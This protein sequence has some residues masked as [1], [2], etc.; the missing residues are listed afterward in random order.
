MRISDINQWTKCEAMALHSGGGRS[1]GY[2]ASAYV[3]TLAHYYLWESAK[4]RYEET[5]FPQPRQVAWDR[6]TIDAKEAELQA[7]H[8]AEAGLLKLKADDWVITETERK[9][10]GGRLDLVAWNGRL[11]KIALLDLKTGGIG[12]GWLQVAGYMVADAGGSVDPADIAF[13]FGGILWVPRVRP[14]RDPVA[15]LEFRPAADLLNAWTTWET[16]IEEVVESG[17]LPL[18]SPGPHCSRCS[19]TG[20]PVRVETSFQA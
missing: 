13:D 20:C 19:L 15:T 7:A 2:P 5:E 18:R 1:I 14:E 4:T 8:I 16:R 17:R 9:V 12:G 10:E 6:I 11:K 3:G